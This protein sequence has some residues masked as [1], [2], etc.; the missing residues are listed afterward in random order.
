MSANDEIILSYHDSLIRSTDYNLLFSREWINDNIIE[1]WFEYMNNHLFKNYQEHLLC[2]GPSMSHLIKFTELQ[3]VQTILQP[4]QIENKKL[5]L[6][7]INDNSYS[8]AAGG[9]H[10]SLLVL[11]VPTRT[12]EHYDSSMYSNN[13]CHAKQVASK[14]NKLLH[15]NS[16]DLVIMQCSQQEDSY[17][18]G[19]HLIC[20]S[21]A[22][23]TKYFLHD[24]RHV[25][26]IADTAVIKLFRRKLIEIIDSLRN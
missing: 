21:K 19:I 7:P 8:E 17:N 23:C 1:F 24:T 5:L 4:L 16:L 22:V 20:N 11:Y 3:D 18:C 14:L 2:I 10:W 12:F 15:G 26:E 9:S 13:I 25:S 6:M